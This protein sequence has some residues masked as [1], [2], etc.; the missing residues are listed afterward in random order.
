MIAGNQ[1]EINHRLIVLVYSELT[2][3]VIKRTQQFGNINR[4]PVSEGIALIPVR[5]H[6]I[7]IPGY[8]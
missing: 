4:F 8:I 2:G 7:Q 3:G 1:P 6:S 5:Q